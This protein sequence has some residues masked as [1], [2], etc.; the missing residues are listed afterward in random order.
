MS[1]INFSAWTV[2]V[3]ES[4]L[5]SVKGS[6]LD[7]GAVDTPVTFIVDGRGLLGEP[8]ITVDGPDSVAKVNVRKQDEGLYQETYI[9]HEVGIF[10]VRVQW[11]K[12]DVAGSPFHPKIVD[13]ARVRLIGGWSSLQDAE[14]RLELIPREEKKLSFDV[15]EAGP[16]RLR[17]MPVIGWA[18]PISTGDHTIVTLRGHGLTTARCG[19]QAEFIIDGLSAGPGAPDVTM[20]GT[21]TDVFVSLRDEGDGVWRA[22]Y[23]LLIP[24]AYLLNVMWSDRQVRGCPLKVSVADAS[25]VV[26]S[27]EGLR[28]GMVGQD[29]KSFIDTRRAGPGELT[30]TCVVPQ[31][32][33]L[34][35]LEDH[36]DGTFI[37][38]IRPQVC[39]SSK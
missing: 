13:P 15:T 5:A 4:G 17:D 24:G 6:G 27:G 23:T 39:V 20:S 9:P 35:D 32:V 33:A 2:E 3:G 16:G 10:Y 21:K 37:L 8:H 25:R 7:G 28:H 1:K 18:E 31:K 22:F 38:N 29:I 14:G 19:E 36:G 11:N 12:R 34:C 30:V 26:C